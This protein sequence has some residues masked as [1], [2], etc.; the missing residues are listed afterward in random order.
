MSMCKGNISMVVMNWLRPEVLQNDILPNMVKYELLDEIIISH[1]REDTYFEFD[2]PKI[3]NRK[4]WGDINEYY[5]LSRRFLAAS[6]ASNEIILMIDDDEYPTEDA[7]KKMYDIHINNPKRMIGPFGQNLRWGNYNL[8]RRYG[9]VCVLITK[10]TMFER[11]LCNQ[12]FKHMPIM[13]EILKEGQPYWN[14]EDIL[15]SAVARFHYGVNNLGVNGCGNVNPIEGRENK[16]ERAIASWKGH[17]E[18]RGKVVWHCAKYF[19]IWHEWTGE[20]K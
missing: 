5:G 1:G 6:E 8:H 4:D 18:Y 16:R 7:V 10:C 11:A 15:M 2:H 17:R 3:V 14:G 13:R 19:D 20:K 9:D 12:F